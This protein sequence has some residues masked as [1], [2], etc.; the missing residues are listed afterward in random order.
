MSI[1]SVS[2]RAVRNVYWTPIAWPSDICTLSA[3]LAARSGC[4]STAVL[5]MARPCASTKWVRRSAQGR[6]ASCRAGSREHSTDVRDVLGAQQRL[7]NAG[8]TYEETVIMLQALGKQRAIPPFK[9]MPGPGAAAPATS[10]TAADIPVAANATSTATV[11]PT[12][13]PD[14]AEGLAD[15]IGRLE[16]R[17]DGIQLD[18]TRALLQQ[19][20]L[21]LLPAE[22]EAQAR[23]SADRY[24]NYGAYSNEGTAAGMSSSS[25]GSLFGSNLP[26]RQRRSG[27]LWRAK[28]AQPLAARGRRPE[29]YLTDDWASGEEG[30]MVPYS[31]GGGTAAAVVGWLL[32]G[33]S[34][35]HGDT[36][37]GR[38]T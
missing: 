7:L 36:T 31:E 11:S 33:L 17:L 28:V 22:A 4:P 1:I 34:R 18:L 27:I 21:G 2:L 8:F 38:C 12:G 30:S 9:E 26:R 14:T 29:R 24:S 15:K 10:A 32:G 20:D 5:R 35:L 23:L 6:S 13:P 19:P 3:M 16:Q 37:T 25:G